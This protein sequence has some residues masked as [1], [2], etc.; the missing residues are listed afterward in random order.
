MVFFFVL[1][2][3]T[4]NKKSKKEESETELEHNA[5]VWI[6]ALLD[7]MDDKHTQETKKDFQ[8]SLNEGREILIE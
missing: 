3:S 2:S 7:R 8:K 1:A 5:R 6:D 4:N